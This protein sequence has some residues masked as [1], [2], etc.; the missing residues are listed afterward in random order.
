MKLT[1]LTS[2]GFALFTALGAVA[3]PVDFDSNSLDVRDEAIEASAAEA[4]V[5]DEASIADE[6]GEV[7]V[8]AEDGEAG[9]LI[10]YDGTCSNRNNQCRYRAQSGR[11][12][13]CR[14]QV[15]RRARKVL[16]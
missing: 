11:T 7:D 16:L 6:A 3:S 1:L 10:R 9:T 2:L 13:I 12:A 15:K 5:F 4:N 8:T 14:C